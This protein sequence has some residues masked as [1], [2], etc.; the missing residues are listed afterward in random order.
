MNDYTLA[1]F[2]HILGVLGLFIGIG[3]DWTTIL[4]LRRAQT[5]T[6]VREQTSLV[7]AQTRLIQFS[8]LL[9]LLAGAYMVETVWRW[10]NPWIFV[11]LGALFVIGALG[12]GLI[13]RR[14][15]AIQRAAA[16]ERTS[17]S[18]PAA[19]QSR[20]ADPVLW[21]ALQTAAFIALG[22]VF[23]MTNKP[24]LFVSLLALGVAIILGLVSA[25]LW[26]RPREPQTL[27]QEARPSSS[28]NVD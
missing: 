15:R 19:L 8:L 17:E 23:L 1:L 26:R 5:M 25:Q 12:G 24:D 21:G 4:R 2:A 14:L 13:D 20:M 27:V 18:I 28:S 9:V 11:S 6:Q 22:V 7:G 16:S 10:E 3:L